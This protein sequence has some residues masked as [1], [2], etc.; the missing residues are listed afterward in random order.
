MKKTTKA[1]ATLLSLAVMAPSVIALAGCAESSSDTLVFGLSAAPTTYCP[2]DI[3]SSSTGQVASQIYDNLVYIAEDYSVEPR[4]AKSW[5]WSDDG[6]TLTFQLNENATWHDGEP[7]TAADYVF[8][9]QWYTSSETTFSKGS[10]G[11]YLTGVDFTT[12][13]ETD[14]DSVG[15]A[16]G[17]NEY[18]LVLSLNNTYTQDVFLYS[19]LK[20]FFVLP[21]HCFLDE[22]GNQLSDQEIYE[23][24]DF[25]SAPIGSGPYKFVSEL[26]GSSVTLEA[27]EDYHLGTPAFKNLIMQVVDTDTAVDKILAGDVDILGYTLDVDVANSYKDRDDITIVTESDASTPVHICFN[28]SRIP[29]NIR[30]AVEYAIDKEDVLEKY[31]GGEGTIIDSGIKPTYPGSEGEH[32]TYDTDVA[33]AYVQAAVD[34]GEWDTDTDVLKIGVVTETN[35][36]IMTYVSSY[37]NAIG[38]RTQVITN[39]MSVIQQSMMADD[40]TDDDDYE[41]GCAV[42]TISSSYYPTIISTYALY[43]E[44][45]FFRFPS[46]M[47]DVPLSIYTEFLYATEDRAKELIAEF[48][49]WEHEY[50]PV[51]TLTL[52][53]AYSATSTRVTNVDS[54]NAS[55]YNHASW[56][57]EKV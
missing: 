6:L 37:L 14:T 22:D 2:P 8:S 27:H 28:S 17:D 46:G 30:Q 49:E 24:T 53:K 4:G 51:V 10:F 7:V 56:K 19:Y 52:Y 43:G 18:E 16:V 44:Y 23:L 32:I 9:L 34:A 41:Y 12:A 55:N 13:T 25:W 48:Q 42:W 3:L 15:A 38:I 26:T 11:K 20:G 47:K 35:A 50:R 36:T 21:Q 57:W 1:M 29:L 31:Y 45:L 33:A 54:F 39:E 5:E 40:G